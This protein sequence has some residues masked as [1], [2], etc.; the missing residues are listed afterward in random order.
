MEQAK[1]TYSPLGE[2]FENQTKT[3]ENQ[4]QKQIKAIEDNKKQ[5][6]NNNVNDYKNELLITKEREIF[7]NIY[8]KSLIK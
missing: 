6:A 5:L 3:I 1:F 7:K 2:A 8:N 4:G